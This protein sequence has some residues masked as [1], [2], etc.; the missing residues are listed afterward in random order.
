[1]RG[2]GWRVKDNGIGNE[3]KKECVNNVLQSTLWKFQKILLILNISENG[4]LSLTIVI[5]RSIFFKNFNLPNKYC[6]A[7]VSNIK[8]IPDTLIF[9]QCLVMTVILMGFVRSQKVL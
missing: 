9:L 2:A 8:Q 5:C 1:M 6:S 4:D 7:I 3:A